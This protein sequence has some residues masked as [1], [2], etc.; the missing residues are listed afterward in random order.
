M[1]IASFPEWLGKLTVSGYHIKPI[2]SDLARA[3]TAEIATA[4]ATAKATLDDSIRRAYVKLSYI[5]VSRISVLS[6]PASLNNSD[7][8][9]QLTPSV[10]PATSDI[11]MRCDGR[12]TE[13]VRAP[14]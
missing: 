1:N 8:T 5:D 14:M 2:Y 12:C 10:R 3:R 4:A 6:F 11:L 9:Q 7:D 13:G